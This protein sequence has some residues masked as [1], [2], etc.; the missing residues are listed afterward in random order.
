MKKNITVQ[1]QPTVYRPEYW[2]TK[3]GRADF[4]ESGKWSD[5]ISMSSS[6]CYQY[7][8]DEA[9]TNLKTVHTEDCS[10]DWDYMDG[11]ER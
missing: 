6:G 8:L 9:E 11:A 2:W 7:W 3:T 10:C 4:A 5:N 1:Y